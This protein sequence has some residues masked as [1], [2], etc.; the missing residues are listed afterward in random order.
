MELYDLPA[1]ELSPEPEIIQPP[2]HPR[3]KATFGPLRIY[4]FD[5]PKELFVGRTPDNDLILEGPF[6]SFASARAF[7]VFSCVEGAILA[8]ET[9]V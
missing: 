3:L 9:K 5:P 4:G 8:L 2:D 6:A 7:I 1:L